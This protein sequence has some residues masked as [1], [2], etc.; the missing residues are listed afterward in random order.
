MRGRPA[1]WGIALGITLPSAL[2][3]CGA[4]PIEAIGQFGAAIPM[5]SGDA[6]VLPRLAFVDEGC[7]GPSAAGGCEATGT[8]A[9]T[10]LLIDS[11]VPLTT[12]ADDTIAPGMATLDQECLEV[13]QAAGLAA[14]PPAAEDLEAAVARFRFDRV[15]VVRVPAEG[16]DDWTW[17]A[18]DETTLLEPGGVLGGNLLRS[19]ALSIRTPPG[20]APVLRVYTEFPGDER[21]LADQG[22]AYLPLQFPGRL[23]GRD[24]EDRCEV[25]GSRCEL[26]GYD[27]RPGQ[28]NI[29]LVATR[30]VMDACIAA[31]PCGLRYDRAP[32]DPFSAGDCDLSPGLGTDTMCEDASGVLGGRSASLVVATGVPDVVLFDDS[33]QRMF[34]DLAALPAC[35]AAVDANTLA[36]LAG[37]DAALAFSGWPDAGFDEPLL[38]LRVRSVAIVPGVVATRDVGPCERVDRR[39]VGLFNQCDRWRRTAD[40]VGDIRDTTPPFSGASDEDD[41]SGHRDD[42]SA[43]S[44]VVLGETS[45]RAETSVPDPTR[46]ITVRVLPATHPLPLTLR[47]DVAPEA[48][49]P[50]GLLGTVLLPGT[51]T[52]LDYTDPNPGLRMRCLDPRAEACASMPECREDGQRACCFGLPLHLLVDY[53]VSAG[54]DTCCGALSA[55]ELEEVQALGHC[56]GLT[57]P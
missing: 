2:P 12:I 21:R 43:T 38:R 5:A 52:I 25:D 6:S 9:C 24:L 14:D 49:Q 28:T 46:W 30:M 57:P 10:P 36:C 3:G 22:R 16:T 37:Q 1:R 31:P 13:R 44:L 15:P 4:D 54:D 19:L 42:P 39:L 48:I 53:I 23:L 45:L 56:Q 26:A 40:A 27:L 20:E 29:A 32:D 50:D 34:G 18:G 55:S 47:R 33:A 51:D 7:P 35:D 11:L 41:G 17:S 8:R